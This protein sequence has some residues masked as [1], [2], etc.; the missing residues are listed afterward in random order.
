MNPKQDLQLRSHIRWMIRRDMA[1]VLDIESDGFEFP[2]SEEDFVRCLRQRNCIGL[3]A[4]HADRVVGFMIYELHKTR[5]HLLNFA[6]AKH[7]GR[8]GV[9]GQMLNKLIAKLSN[10]RRTR[11][12]LEVRETNL[13]AQLFFRKMGFRA[14]SVLR[15]FYDDTTEDAYLMQYRYRPVETEIVV[16]INRITRLAG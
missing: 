12:V 10:Q 16:P 8:R 14:V 5:L 1:E 13:A 3:V 4:E 9:G 2:W 11:I 15:D 7:A 6:V